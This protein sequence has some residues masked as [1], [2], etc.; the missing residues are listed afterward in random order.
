MLVFDQESF[1]VVVKDPSLR[2]AE[3]VC[4]F[5]RIRRVEAGLIKQFREFLPALTKKIE[6]FFLLVVTLL[7]RAGGFVCVG[8]F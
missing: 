2:F 4:F 6:L 8:V 5:R 3:D 1:V 7:R